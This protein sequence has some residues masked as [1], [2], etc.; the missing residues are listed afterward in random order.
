MKLLVVHH[1]MC[2]GIDFYTYTW[3]QP[4]SDIKKGTFQ[5]R[6]CYIDIELRTPY[7]TTINV[8]SHNQALQLSEDIILPQEVLCLQTQLSCMLSMY[9]GDVQKLLPA[10]LPTMASEDLHTHA[11]SYGASHAGGDF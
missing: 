1:T 4:L 11:H 7:N 8:G 9:S 6:C 2:F 10:L 5:L 3:C